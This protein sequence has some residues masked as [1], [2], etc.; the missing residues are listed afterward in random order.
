[1]KDS[2]RLARDCLTL[3]LWMGVSSLTVCKAAT[4]IG[5]VV[6]SNWRVAV[7]ARRPNNDRNRFTI[8]VNRNENIIGHLPRK[9]STVCSL[10]LRSGG[11]I[12]CTLSGNRR[13]S[14]LT[15]HMVG[16]R[17]HVYVYSLVKSGD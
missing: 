15:Y 7:C 5:Y 10:F 13:Y 11:S 9:I 6:S 17:F 14:Q 8:A 2:A 16:L 3:L 1:M 12:R 4:Y